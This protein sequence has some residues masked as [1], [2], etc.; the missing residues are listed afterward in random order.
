MLMG[1]LLSA[2][3]VAMVRGA[4]IA[5][6][7]PATPRAIWSQGQHEL[8]IALADTIIPATDTVGATAVHVDEFIAHMLGAWFLPAA[9]VRFATDLHYFE[10]SCKK[11][12]GAPF[13][14]LDAASRL[15][16]LEP[17]DRAAV[18]ARI[19]RQNPLPFFATVKELTLVGYYTSAG[20]AAAIGYLGPISARADHLGPIGS[21]IWN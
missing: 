7:S 1:G 19:Q 4:E 11:T 16:Y 8:I 21:R 3:L 13:A 6:S 12:K 17:L 14:S 2:P 20:G 18:A 10:L 5:D 9:R 15:E